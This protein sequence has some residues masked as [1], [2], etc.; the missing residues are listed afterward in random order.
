MGR[1]HEGVRITSSSKTTLAAPDK[2]DW[3]AVFTT[4]DSQALISIKNTLNETLSSNQK[5]AAS[6]IF[7]KD[8]A[9]DGL[10]LKEPADGVVVRQR[11]KGMDCVVNKNPKR[12]TYLYLD[13]D[14]RLAFQGG[15]HRMSVEIKLQSN[16]PLDNIKLQY[17]SEGPNEIATVYRAVSPS[18][19]KQQDDWSVIGFEA[20]SPYLGNRQNSG[21][22]FR[23]FLDNCL[24][25]IASLKVTLE[26]CKLIS[27][28]QS[29]MQLIWFKI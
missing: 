28:N 1:S 4:P 22:D 7:A 18:W 6:I 5:S 17:D 15:L 13:L 2:K 29:D 3:L 24:C 14:D 8:A 23:I 25:H 11:F 27:T 20:D 16:N 12:N 26:Q 19:R 10:V 21:A 9:F